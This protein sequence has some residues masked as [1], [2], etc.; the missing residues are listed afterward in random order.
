MHWISSEIVCFVCCTLEEGICTQQVVTSPSLLHLFA[1]AF[2]F[3]HLRS[4]TLIIHSLAVF[5]L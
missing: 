4:F 1:L 2:T 5:F 3:F